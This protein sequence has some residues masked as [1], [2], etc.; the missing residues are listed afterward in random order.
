MSTRSATRNPRSNQGISGALATAAT[1]KGKR[2]RN[3]EDVQRDSPAP[4][5]N[6]DNHPASNVDCDP[7]LCA[8]CRNEYCTCYLARQEEWTQHLTQA[9]EERTYNSENDRTEAGQPIVN[10]PARNYISAA[11]R[12]FGQHFVPCNISA[13]SLGPRYLEVPIP[14]RQEI[15]DRWEEEK[16]QVYRDDEEI[17]CD[18]C[19]SFTGEVCICEPEAASAAPEIHQ[20][21]SGFNF[22]QYGRLIPCSQCGS[23]YCICLNPDEEL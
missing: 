4:K 17:I 11:D 7:E 3:D 8:D 21:K 6:R 23:N 12:D 15:Y 19:F 2:K 18:K 22:D 16:D 10:G 1:S 13:V 20:R 14:S 5:R 9:D